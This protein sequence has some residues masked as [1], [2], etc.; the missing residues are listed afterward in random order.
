MKQKMYKP[1]SLLFTL[2]GNN[3]IK[4]CINYTMAYSVA[5]A[6]FFNGIWSTIKSRVCQLNGLFVSDIFSFGE[7]GKEI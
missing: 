2:K 6:M 1:L 5:M 3:N 7:E 4:I